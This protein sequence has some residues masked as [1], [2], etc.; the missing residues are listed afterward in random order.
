MVTSLQFSLP[1][2]ALGDVTGYP[3]D[4]TYS[5]V[6]IAQGDDGCLTDTL[7][8]IL[9]GEV[10]LT[11]PAVIAQRSVDNSRRQRATGLAKDFVFIVAEHPLRCRVPSDDFSFQIGHDD[12]V[13]DIL[14]NEGLTT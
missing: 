6:F 9:A 10:H 5:T 14:K 3:K 4:S 13:M 11:G 2:L 7:S 12:A 8:P 1:L